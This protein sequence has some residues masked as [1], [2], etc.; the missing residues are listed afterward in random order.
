MTQAEAAAALGIKERRVRSLLAKFKAEGY[1]GLRDRSIGQPGH[2]CLPE[3]T[4]RA[5]LSLAREKYSDAGPTLLS[6]LLKEHHQINVSRETLRRWLLEAA[7]REVKSAQTRHRRQRARKPCFGSMVQM[8]TSEHD[9]FKQEKKVYLIATIDDA[10]NILDGQFYE[11]DSTR[12]NMMAMKRYITRN[13]RPVSFYTDRASHFKI[14]KDEKSEEILSHNDRQETQIQRALKEC[15][16]T[17][18]H[19]L[20]PQGKGRVE[21]KFQML[22]DRLVKR[23]H[24]DNIKDIKSANEYLDQY[25]L[26]LHNKNYTVKPVSEVNVHT[27]VGDLN[28]D[29]IFSIQVLRTVTNDFT[30]SL[31]NKKYQI[32]RNNDLVG[33][34]RK[35]VLIEKRLDGSLHVRYLGRYLFFHEIIKNSMK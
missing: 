31:D 16:I 11:N 10:T 6:D 19:A 35:K 1:E 22:Q 8:D 34:P 18:I 24:Y 14:N 15:N 26:D 30:F 17:L 29:A 4:K 2:H 33:L 12:T 20:S 7:L 13:G 5:V 32:E 25:Y 28:L 9:W 3:E 23:M 27:P 21:R